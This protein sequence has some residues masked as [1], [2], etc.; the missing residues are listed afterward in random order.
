MSRP[1]TQTPDER[2]AYKRAW[3]AA[4][5]E[6]VNAMQR[7]DYRRHCEARKE[8][9]REYSRRYW[10]KKHPKAEPRVPLTEAEREQRYQEKLRRQNAKRKAQRAAARLAGTSLVMRQIIRDSS[11]AAKRSPSRV[12]QRPAESVEEFIARHPERYQR[13]PPVP[14]QPYDVIP[15]RLV[16]RGRGASA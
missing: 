5:R 15:A 9:Q 1:K 8:K 3:R 4:N 16:V 2:R 11:A 13:I 10:A 14:S 6:H 7:N 12:A